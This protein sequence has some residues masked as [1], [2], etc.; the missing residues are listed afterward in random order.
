MVKI[1]IVSNTSWSLLNFRRNLIKYLADKG[2]CVIACAPSD[3]YTESLKALV[4]EF[5]PVEIDAYGVNPFV[6]IKLMANY[7]SILKKVMPNVCLN[8]T[9]KPNIYCTLAA[10]V[11]SI[12]CINNIAGLGQVFIRDSVLTLI[13]KTLYRISLK[14]SKKVFFQNEDDMDLFLKNNIVSKVSVEKLPGSGICVD[15][16]RSSSERE[17]ESGKLKFAMISRLLKEKGVHEYVEAA[18]II[19]KKYGG[20]QFEIVGFVD[21]KNKKMVSVEQLEEW[22]KEGVVKYLGYTDD[23]K[24]YLETVSCVVLPSFYREGV[25]RILLEAAAMCRPLITTNVIGCRDAVEDN[26]NG[27]LCEPRNIDSLVE[28]IEKMIGLSTSERESMGIKSRE[29]M[30]KEFDDGIVNERYLR[31][32]QGAVC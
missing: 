12:P 19:K 16:Y 24:S 10:N 18:R 21:V 17:A 30:S 6:D 8:Y 22:D 13:V 28:C 26:V 7:F 29:K 31:A 15:T 32:I 11:L 27:Y 4:H 5:Y 2:F 20:V 23:V 3:E 9:I 25:P 1:L 14:K